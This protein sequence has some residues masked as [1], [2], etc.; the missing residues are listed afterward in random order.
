MTPAERKLWAY[1]RRDQLRAV[2]F[3][4][5]HCIGP[6]VADF[7]SPK[8]KLIIEVDGGEHMNQ[9]E[10][11]QERTA[12]LASKGYRVIRFWNH[13]VMNNMNAVIAAIMAALP[14]LPCPPPN[15][16]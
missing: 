2:N 15:A 4:R 10:H 14:P 16:K 1:L 12:F 9:I 5:Q 3:R 6:Y 13:D 8:A 7:C 11:D